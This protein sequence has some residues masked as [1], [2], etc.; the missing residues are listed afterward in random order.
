M[1]MA[2]HQARDRGTVVQGE[3]CPG[4]PLGVHA[5]QHRSAVSERT[6]RGSDLSAGIRQTQFR[7]L[8][9]PH[10]EVGPRLLLRVEQS[11]A[12]S[13][14]QARAALGRERPIFTLSI[15]K[16]VPSSAIAHVSC[17]PSKRPD[18]DFAP[19][20]LQAEG[21]LHQPRPAHCAPELKRQVRI[22]SE[23][24]LV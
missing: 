24:A 10:D 7:A 12:P 15:V 8:L 16:R 9:G 2:I 5:T 23:D 1:P 18:V 13:R 3:Y 20:R 14:A 6:E 19:V 21:C 11:L 22:R 17:A 4:L